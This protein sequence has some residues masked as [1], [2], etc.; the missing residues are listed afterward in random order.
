MLYLQKL[1]DFPPWLWRS[2][3]S[4]RRFLSTMIRVGLTMI[5]WFA[6]ATM[7]VVAYFLAG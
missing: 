1:A 6:I 5:R 2:A 7:A 4:A 3:R